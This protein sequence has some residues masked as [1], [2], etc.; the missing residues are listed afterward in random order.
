MMFFS[1]YLKNQ[2]PFKNC[3]IT[4][5]TRDSLNRK[6]SKSLGN[7][8]DPID[9]IQKYGA[10][11]LRLYLL[12]SS[13]PGEDLIYNEERIKGSWNFINKL[14]NSFRFIQIETK[15]FEYDEAKIPSSFNLFDK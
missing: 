15:E 6:M 1:L 3:Y 9:L 2:I 8:I 7:G 14:W 13:S 11:A 4:G 10:D 12:S 5:L